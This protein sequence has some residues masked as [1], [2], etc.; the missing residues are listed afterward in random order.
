VFVDRLLDAAERLARFPRS[1]RII[2]EI[3]DPHS[4]EM[5]FGAYRVMYHV[6]RDAVIIVSVV[7]GARHW[8]PG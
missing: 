4:R 3:G 7:H 6:E 8:P 2:P 1:G 5:I